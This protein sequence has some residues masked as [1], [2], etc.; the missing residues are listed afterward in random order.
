LTNLSFLCLGVSSVG[1]GRRFE[2]LT[3]FELF[4]LSRFNKCGGVLS[5]STK[6]LCLGSSSVYMSQ[7]F[8]AFG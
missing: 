3:K 2:L 5:F 4:V 7:E 1:V 6:H 8:W